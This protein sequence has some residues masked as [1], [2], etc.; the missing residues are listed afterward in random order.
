MLQQATGHRNLRYAQKRLMCKI[1]VLK[2]TAQNGTCAS[3][4]FNATAH[5]QNLP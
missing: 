5:V 1:Q 4:S 3:H 2:L